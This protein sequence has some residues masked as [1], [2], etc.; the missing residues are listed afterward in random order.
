MDNLQGHD[1]QT[2]VWIDR[3]RN[4]LTKIWHGVAIGITAL[5]WLIAIINLVIYIKNYNKTVLSEQSLIN[6][7]GNFS[8][9]S[10]PVNLSLVSNGVLDAG[11]DTADA[12][13]IVKN[14]NALFSARFSYSFTIAGETIEIAEAFIMPDQ[15]Q[16]FV[17]RGVPFDGV[18]KDT[19]FVM[20]NVTWEKLHGLPP[21]T[22]FD[23][24]DIIFGRSD[25]VVPITPDESVDRTGATDVLNTNSVETNINVDTNLNSNEVVDTISDESEPEFATPD[26][27][28]N[29]ETDTDVVI[30]SNEITA[31]YGTI[32]NNSPVG[33]RSA[34]VIA[35]VRD[36]SGTIIGVHKQILKDFYS[37][38][39]QPISMH[40]PRRFVFNAQPE[41]LVYADYL[42]P[43]NLIL[44]GED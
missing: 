21:N 36:E 43:D 31:L 6:Q 9:I 34:I 24:S 27:P 14:S 42:N 1:L 35:V 4:L 19:G 5:I 3:H 8:T 23:I 16:I 10:R 28:D 30:N 12:Y 26:D 13:A 40:W 39:Q 37:F 7:S 15:E 17:A 41:L 18:G 25:V 29:T 2:A 22:Q 11:G 33:F 44:L 38:D 32:S 20:E